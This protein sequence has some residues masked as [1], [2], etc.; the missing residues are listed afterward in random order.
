MELEKNDK[1]ILMK[2]LLNNKKFLKLRV[3]KVYIIKF[4]L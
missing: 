3:N 2:N 4:A 1:I